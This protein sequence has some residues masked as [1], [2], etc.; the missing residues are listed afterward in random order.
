[1]RQFYDTVYYEN[2]VA[3]TTVSGH[4][5][6]LASKI[7]IRQGQRLLDVGCGAGKWLFS[8]IKRGAYP[9]GVDLSQ[10]AIAICKKTLPWGGV[11][12]GAAEALPF[13]DKQFHV[14]SCLGSLEHFLD[15]E[16]A[17]EEIVRVARDDAIF[18]LLVPN[19]DFLTRRLGLYGGT[20]Q[21]A[22]REQV[23]TLPQWQELFEA[24]GLKVIHRWRDLHVLR[25]HG[26][27]TKNG[28]I[29]RFVPSRQSRCYFG[30]YRGNIRFTICARRIRPERNRSF[31]KN[32]GILYSEQ[33]GY[34]K[35]DFY[36]SV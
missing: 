26:L 30:R 9:V 7:K 34:L 3:D 11:C 32:G 24:S 31:E 13:H 12:L 20:D 19:A 22:V 5:L 29:F 23:R 15:S 33:S 8:A 27:P 16:S 1:M 14:V 2:A 35:Y 36:P 4:L 17:L 21:S 6:R 18:L 28:I 25:G 10:K